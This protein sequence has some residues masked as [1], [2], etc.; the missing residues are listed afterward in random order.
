MKGIRSVRAAIALPNHP[1]GGP[2]QGTE[3]IA[4]GAKSLCGAYEMEPVI[5][6]DSICRPA[7]LLATDRSRA[8]KVETEHDPFH[9]RRREISRSDLR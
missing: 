5:R 2:R 3:S 7:H 6:L 1:T 9:F 8:V 4:L